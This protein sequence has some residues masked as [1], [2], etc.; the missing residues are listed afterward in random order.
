MSSNTVFASGAAYRMGADPW[1]STRPLPSQ[2]RSAYKFAIRQANVLK[3]FYEFHEP[4][5]MII[6]DIKLLFLAN[7]NMKDPHSIRWCIDRVY[8]HTD[9]IRRGLPDKESIRNA[10][11]ASWFSYNPKHSFLADPTDTTATTP[12]LSFYGRDVTIHEKYRATNRTVKAAIVDHMRT[13]A[14]PRAHL[15]DFVENADSVARN[16]G[17]DAILQAHDVLG[18]L[19]HGGPLVAAFTR[20]LQRPAMTPGARTAHEVGYMTADRLVRPQLEDQEGRAEDRQVDVRRLRSGEYGRQHIHDIPRP[21]YQPVGGKVV[22]RVVDGELVAVEDDVAEL[23]PLRGI[24][25]F[26]NEAFSSPVVAAMSDDYRAS[27]GL[28]TCPP[29]TCG[30]DVGPLSQADPVYRLTTGHA[31]RTLLADPRHPLHR[32]L[33]ETVMAFE[34]AEETLPLPVDLGTHAAFEP[35]TVRRMVEG[36]LA[37]GVRAGTIDDE[38]QLISAAR[39]A[40]HLCPELAGTLQPMMAFLEAQPRERTC[41]RRLWAAHPAGP[42]LT[43]LRRFL[44]G[45]AAAADELPPGELASAAAQAEFNPSRAL[46]ILFAREDEVVADIERAVQRDRPTAVA[47]AE[48]ADEKAR[49]I[50]DL[51]HRRRRMALSVPV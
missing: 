20:G 24:D 35:E 27:A 50:T 29:P 5:A 51:R 10:F 13:W 12:F 31:V 25:P 3:H 40:A 11:F 42:Q 28:P 46:Q 21:L 19:P 22:A 33:A 17:V 49:R 44:E 37:D 8:G 48:Q 32:T 14:A 7:K 1:A 15:A 38:A 36:P 45:D 34:G 23:E 4:R 47:K 9:I 2:V 41:A 16:V 6:R 26:T 39:Y 18:C 43:A 30:L